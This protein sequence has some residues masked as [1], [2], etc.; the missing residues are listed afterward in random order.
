VKFLPIEVGEKYGYRKKRYDIGQPLRP[1][2]VTKIGPP[3]SSKFRIRWLEGEYEGLEEWVRRDVLLCPWE[4][5]DAFVTE[6]VQRSQAVAVSQHAYK[7]DEWIAVREVFYD[8]DGPFQMAEWV[9]HHGLIAIEGFPATVDDYGL[10][11]DELLGEPHAFVTEDG[12]YFATFTTAL[13]IAQRLCEKQ[14][15]RIITNMKRQLQADRNAAAS[16]WYRSPHGGPGWEISLE[17]AQKSSEESARILNIVSAWCGTHYADHYDHVTELQ[18]ESTRI[19]HLLSD[20]LRWM[21]ETADAQQLKWLKAKYRELYTK[22]NGEPPPT[23]KQRK[24]KPTAPIGALDR[25][26]FSE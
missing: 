18:A 25:P 5:A 20:T 24:L 9:R 12:T 3:K 14:P 17:T 4:K 2:L 8:I 7:T 23:I 16:G 11:P 22:L 15:T 6:E 21:Q 13:R 10:T 26:K 19:R 1:V